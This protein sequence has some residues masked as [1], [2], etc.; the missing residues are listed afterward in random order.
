MQHRLRGR[1]PLLRQQWE[2][3]PEDYFITREE[4]RQWELITDLSWKTNAAQRSSTSGWPSA[5][6]KASAIMRRVSRIYHSLCAE[7]RIGDHTGPPVPV[8]E[9]NAAK[10]KD[11][12][13]HQRDRKRMAAI[14]EAAASRSIQNE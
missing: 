10:G 4:R 2:A 6:R 8:I 9:A 1:R 14:L 7:S 5:R 13:K 3:S 11:R 12:L